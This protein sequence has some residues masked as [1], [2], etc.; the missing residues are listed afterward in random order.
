G[1]AGAA[2]AVDRRRPLPRLPH[3]HRLA[4][5]RRRRQEEGL[6]A[7]RRAL[8]AAAILCAS[9]LARA[10]GGLPISQHI[11]RQ[12]GGDQMFVPVVFWGLW[13]SQPD[14]RWKWICE[15]LIN[16]NR[17]R[18]FALSTDGTFYTTDIK[19]LT[20]S[21]DRGCTWTAATGAIANLHAT[22]VDADPVDGATAYAAIGDG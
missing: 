17:T 13:V 3:R 1:A 8:A 15:E 18:R 21:T 11:L 10:H 19:G 7:V 12:A 2:G 22:D 4:G 9:S 16:Q 5:V 6:R 20:L 14:G